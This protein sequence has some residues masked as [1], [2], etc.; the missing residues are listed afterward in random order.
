MLDLFQ[1][2]ASTELNRFIRKITAWGAIGV[3]GTL[4][5]G[6]Y[7]MNFVHMPE[8][9][10]QLGYPMALGMILIVGVVLYVL[11]RRHGWL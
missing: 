2:R 10:W 7:G 1:T 4:I 9:E 8:L 6:I 3:A 5:A 11:F